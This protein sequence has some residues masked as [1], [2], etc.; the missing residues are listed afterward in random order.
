MIIFTVKQNQFAQSSLSL[1][2]ALADKQTLGEPI[3]GLALIADYK[4]QFFNNLED[5]E[6]AG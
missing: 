3:C 5:G 1:D 4:N 6:L 2:V